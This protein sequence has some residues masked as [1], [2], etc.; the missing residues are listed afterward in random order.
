MRTLAEHIDQQIQANRWGHCAVYE[1]ELQRLWSI[2]MEDRKAAIERFSKEYG[3][4]LIYYGV[5]SARFLK[6][7][8]PAPGKI[9][10]AGQT[11]R[12]AFCRFAVPRNF[13]NYY[14][15]SKIRQRRPVRDVSGI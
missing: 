15:S 12:F 11:F 13:R 8:R 9:D 5:E 10:A 6:K 3:F 4:R 14:M 1:E 2:N 7:S